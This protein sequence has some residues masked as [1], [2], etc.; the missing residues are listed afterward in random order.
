[1]K[2]TKSLS[3]QILALIVLSLLSFCVAFTFSVKGTAKAEVGTPTLTSFK[4]LDGASIRT[5]DPLGIRFTAEISKDE[6]YE[7]LD[8][9][10]GRS[11]T[12]GMVVG[13]NVTDIDDLKENGIKVQR[14]LWAPDDNPENPNA[15]IYRYN[16]AIHGLKDTSSNAEYTA[17]G[18]YAVDGEIVEYASTSIMRTP[19]QIATA[20]IAKYGVDGL[21]TDEKD[22]VVGIVDNVMTAG[23]AEFKF[24][25]SSV[26]VNCFEEF[27]PEVTVDGVAVTPIY[28]VPNDGVA[29]ITADGKI[30]GLKEGQTTVTATLASIAGEN[31][32]S[33]MTLNVE[34]TTVTPVV[35]PDGT[36]SLNTNG[37]ETTVKID[38]VAIEGI[39]T[40]DT[41][42]IVDYILD[43]KNVTSE[44]EFTISVE[45][46]GC[47]GEVDHTF[48]PVNQDSFKTTLNS[49]T[50]ANK[51]KVHYFLTSDISLTSS[52]VSK[53][54]IYYTVFGPIHAHLDGRGYKVAFETTYTDASTGFAGLFEACDVTWSNVHFDMDI[55]IA[56][57]AMIDA[58][59]STS[60]SSRTTG[61]VNGLLNCYFD[62]KINPY[63]ESDD[64]FTKT[65]CLFNASAGKYNNNVFNINAPTGCVVSITSGGIGKTAPTFNN[66]IIISSE[67][68]YQFVASVINNKTITNGY[69]YNSMKDMLIGGNY[70]KVGNCVA[71][72]NETV[73]VT[74]AP[75]YGSFGDNWTFDKDNGTIELCGREVFNSELKVDIDV[76]G[77]VTFDA[78]GE[79]AKL[80]VDTVEVADATSG[81]NLTD[82][83]F[84]IGLT[85]DK[86]YT[87][88]VESASYAGEVTKTYKA[89]TNANFLETVNQYNTAANSNIYFYLTEN[90][91]L[92]GKNGGSNLGDMKYEV[93]PSSNYLCH[94]VFENA[95]FTLDGRGYTLKLAWIHQSNW[96]GGGLIYN[97]Y[98]NW[99][100]LVFDLDASFGDLCPSTFVYYMKADTESGQ[101]GAFTNCYFDVDYGAGKA[102][103]AVIT[104]FTAG[105]I[106]NCIFDIAASGSA[107]PNLKAIGTLSG[108]FK[109]N[110]YVQTKIAS[111][112]ATR[113]PFTRIN[114]GN[115][116]N[117]YNYSTISDFVAGTN[118]VKSTWSSA[119]TG[120][121]QATSTTA[122]TVETLSTIVYTNWNKV[123]TINA[124]DGIKLCGQAIYTPVA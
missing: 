102:N 49:A 57:D 16:V 75:V 78:M 95:F 41:L 118:G 53:H 88:K 85:G 71:S 29:E 115:E 15:T 11:V 123:W 9:Y 116:G 4:A 64:P 46:A 3:K 27:A 34:K 111:D 12:L 70:K 68:N 103:E 37:A 81:F 73:E 8:S 80:Y 7:L 33:T 10:E 56:K 104:N 5:T 105:E 31:Y 119:Y 87:V 30:K 77:V 110:V 86:T 72:L 25:E 20:H 61:A 117:L 44:T 112:T 100:N 65:I 120:A 93:N 48:V 109:D 124:T 99:K 113:T 83:A 91:E 62:V 108:V 59:F 55:T 40:D 101:T 94:Y 60:N 82:Y 107:T 6:Y 58:L 1:M 22:F 26:T 42:N 32:T 47:T 36:L 51:G 50:E 106:R 67:A 19:L 24:T 66:N 89:L 69:L 28:S 43:N 18:Y 114:S 92:Q 54:W 63:E 52:D 122:Y 98:G 45:S 121:Y 13:R 14:S 21:E 23:A 96:R 74:N 35:N 38:D 2:S 90:V 76:D 79:E 97:H 17:L 84:K 39:Y